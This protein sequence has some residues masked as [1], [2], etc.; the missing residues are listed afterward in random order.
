MLR[1]VATVALL[2]L[3][4]LLAYEVYLTPGPHGPLE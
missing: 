2:G 4:S 3:V 1:V